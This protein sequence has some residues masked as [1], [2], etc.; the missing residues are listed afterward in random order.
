MKRNVYISAAASV[1]LMVGGPVAAAAAAST[2]T[3]RAVTA[4]TAPRVDVTADGAAAAALKEYPG[5]VE[6][7]DKDGSAWHVDVI[8]KDGT[9]HAELEVDA[10]SGAVTTR[11]KETGQDSGE[12]KALLDA[13]VTAQQAIKAAL[14]AYPGQVQS[15]DWDDDDDNGKAPY[16]HV[17]VKTASDK[18]WDTSVDATTAKVSSR[19]DSDS[20]SGQDENR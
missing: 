3:A 16:W 7:L 15:V 11:D 5:V 1:V 17:E 14:A 19:S 2:D 9:G 6:S 8:S 4:A 18:T 13:K 12:N 20:N 10:I